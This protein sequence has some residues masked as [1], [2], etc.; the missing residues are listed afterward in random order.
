MRSEDFK[1]PAG[2]AESGIP[3]FFEQDDLSPIEATL[4]FGK[5]KLAVHAKDRPALAVM[6]FCPFR[7]G[8]FKQWTLTLCR[9]VLG[10]PI[11]LSKA[12]VLWGETRDGQP[13]LYFTPSWPA[14]FRCLILF[15][16]WRDAERL[17]IDLR[18]Y[19]F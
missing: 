3:V 15:Q 4:Y 1:G 18:T 13:C 8:R 10:R 6:R 16:D 2:G 17:A 14:D 12:N 7:G 19:W 9:L 5:D 11:P